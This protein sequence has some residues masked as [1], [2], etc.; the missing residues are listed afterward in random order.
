MVND[1]SIDSSSSVSSDHKAVDGFLCDHR[2]LCRGL[3]IYLEMKMAANTEAVSAQRQTSG[4]KW[5][6][7]MTKFSVHKVR[8]RHYP[9]DVPQTWP[10]CQCLRCFMKRKLWRLRESCLS[11]QEGPSWDIQ[12]LQSP[13]SRTG[14]SSP[15]DL[16]VANSAPCHYS[17]YWAYSPS[18]DH[19]KLRLAINSLISQV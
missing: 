8:T 16:A 11:C 17:R 12:G 9:C 6:V 14:L 10:F 1:M 3:P 15:L 2:K 7:K 5:W 13:A 18:T 4:N 19:H